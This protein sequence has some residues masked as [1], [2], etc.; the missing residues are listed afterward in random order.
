MP[1]KRAKRSKREE[2]RVQTGHDLAPSKQALTT[3]AIPKSAARVINALQIRSAFSEKKRQRDLE[4]EGSGSKRRKLSQPKAKSKQ[5]TGLQIQ[6][7]ES[8]QHFNK[9]VENDMR[10]L[11]K[12]AMQTS[13]VVVR[14][15]AKA[16]REAKAQKHLKNQPKLTDDNE[17]SETAT[18]KTSGQHLP[19]SDSSTTDR[20]AQHPVK[21]FIPLNTS[22]PRRLNDIAKAPPELKLPRLRGKSTTGGMSF[23]SSD[24]V[25]S[26]AQ[27][28][29]M[30]EERER[31][32]ARYR[33]LKAKQREGHGSGVSQEDT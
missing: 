30:E 26:M 9:R 10:P 2:L 16:E 4:E 31:V 1:H 27:K 12:S 5:G 6:P 14:T 23:G 18:L 29:M 20:R 19:R 7:G 28:L 21:D 32:I 33:A 24:G 17:Q 25:V 8:I 13:R 3:E 22:V 15:A 11:V